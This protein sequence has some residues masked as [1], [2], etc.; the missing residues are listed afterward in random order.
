MMRFTGL[1][2]IATPSSA[3][4]RRSRTY[5]TRVKT[6][7]LRR[8]PDAAQRVA[9]AERCTAKPGPFSSLDFLAIPGLQRTVTLRFTL[10]CARETRLSWRLSV[11]PAGDG[12]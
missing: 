3:W 11:K 10:R 5:K 4:A 6:P 1:M 8:V 12:D 2:D 9:V 7:G